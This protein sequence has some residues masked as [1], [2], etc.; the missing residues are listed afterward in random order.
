MEYTVSDL[1]KKFN[2]TV[3]T[4]HHYDEISL[5]K[6]SIRMVSGKRF[7]NK[8]DLICLSKILSLKELGFGLKKIQSILLSDP[9]HMTLFLQSQKKAIEDEINQLEKKQQLIDLIIKFNKGKSP[10]NMTDEELNTYIEHLK[11]NKLHDAL[12]DEK[13]MK[14]KTDKALDFWK[15]KNQ[16]HAWLTMQENLAKLD[17]KASVR[18]GTSIGMIGG[19]LICF[20]Q[21]NK[22]PET[23]EV[24]SLIKEQWTIYR[25]FFPKE[26]LKEIYSTFK[27]MFVFINKEQGDVKMAQFLDRAMTIFL[28]KDFK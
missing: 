27:D 24:Q 26:N 1:A 17:E 14:E 6:P 18:V 28:E 5:L 4:L 10:M 8:T 21:E 2:V 25:E 16:A 3:R 9:K 7:Y 13:R 19:N 11:Q 22:E 12:V 15:S 20:C 23:K